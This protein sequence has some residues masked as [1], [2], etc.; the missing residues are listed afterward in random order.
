MTP[1]QVKRSAEFLANARLGGEPTGQPPADLIPQSEADAY[2]VQAM[3]NK[4]LEAGGHGDMVG[5]KIGCT[6]P[7]MQ[8]YLGI[9]HPCAGEVLAFSV[10]AHDAVLSLSKFHRVGVECEIAVRLGHS[11][12]D[13]GGAPYN[14]ESVVPAVESVMAGIE[15]VDDRY[16]DYP[17]LSAPT[18]IADDFFS[19]G[20]V[21]G[22]PNLDFKSLDLAAIKGEMRVDGESIGNGTGADILDHPF[23]ALAWLANHRIAQGK[24]LHAGEFV[25]LGSLV[26]TMFFDTPAEVIIDLD[27]LGRVGVRFI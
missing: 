1:D 16:E 8:E 4:I 2:T 17:S 26:K 9:D 7:V 11:L 23:N 13:T 22:T 15:L 25:M 21:L 14:R 10:H 5:H 27:H 3:L 18:L 12:P 20:V 6:T 24:P 19:A